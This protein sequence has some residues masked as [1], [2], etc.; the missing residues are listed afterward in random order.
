[1]RDNEF[2]NVWDRDKRANE[3]EKK[4]VESERERID[5][6]RECMRKRTC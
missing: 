5:I 1:M 3:K 2:A 4:M 6:L